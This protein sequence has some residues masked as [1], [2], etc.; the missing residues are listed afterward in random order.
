MHGKCTIKYKDG[1]SY[2]GD[3]KNGLYNGVGLL[4]DVES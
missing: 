4:I 2:V 1:S 3:M